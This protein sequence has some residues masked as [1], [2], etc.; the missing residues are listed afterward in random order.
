MARRPGN[1]EAMIERTWKTTSAM[2]TTSPITS[3]VTAAPVEAWSR[4]SR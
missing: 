1:G 4:G 3:M 2:S